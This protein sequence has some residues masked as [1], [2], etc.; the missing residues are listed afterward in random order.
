M[1]WVVQTD[2][3]AR[4]DKDPW[5]G[6]PGC[7]HPLSIAGEGCSSPGQ[8]GLH[9]QHSH[10]RETPAHARN[11]LGHPLVCICP[12]P[13]RNIPK[14]LPGSLWGWRSPGPVPSW[15]F[16]CSQPGW[17]VRTFAGVAEGHHLPVGLNAQKCPQAHLIS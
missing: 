14:P 12:N 4:S 6:I 5:R 13:V 7:W 9:Q 2:F 17:V 3:P 10:A 15:C 8:F 1:T 16:G 11:L